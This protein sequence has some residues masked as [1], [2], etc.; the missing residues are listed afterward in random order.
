MKVRHLGILADQT[1]WKMQRNKLIHST[2]LKKN[3]ILFFK[4]T[5]ALQMALTIFKA[6]LKFNLRQKSDKVNLKVFY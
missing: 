4:N 1:V 6:R 2:F 3:N 5:W